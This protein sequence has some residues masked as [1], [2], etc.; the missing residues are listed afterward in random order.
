MSAYRR[1]VISLPFIHTFFFAGGGGGAGDIWVHFIH[2]SR[3]HKGK[4][5]N[6]C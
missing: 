1:V 2:W 4:M 6:A 5:K 3:G